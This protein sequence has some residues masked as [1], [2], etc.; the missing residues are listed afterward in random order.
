MN[1]R[2]KLGRLKRRVLG[3]VGGGS[4]AKAP[5]P[6]NSADYWNAKFQVPEFIYTTTANQFVVELAT[7]LKP[8]RAIDLAGGEGRNTVWLAEQGWRAENVD[9]ARAGLDKT[10][11]LADERGVADRVTTTLGSATDFQAKLAPADLGVIAYLQAPQEL[12]E[13]A[14]A[15]M[16]NQLRP[17]AHLIGVWHALE[18]LEGGFGGPRD[19][20]ILA[21][22]PHIRAACEAAG[23]RVKTCENRQGKIQTTEGLKPSITLVLL[24]EKP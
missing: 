18:N 14:I 23:L 17:G 21:H 1:I 13:T 24:A 3:V 22:G 12:L 5:I 11:R 8:G 2:A 19:P 4:T 6:A 10:R 9:I 15:R 7:P 16:A 20:R